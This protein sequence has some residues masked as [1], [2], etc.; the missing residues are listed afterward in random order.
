MYIEMP[1]LITSKEVVH[2][3]NAL[4]YFK[5]D[6]IIS[7]LSE[8]TIKIFAETRY[9]LYI[10]GTLVAV[11]PCKPTSETKYY[12]TVDVSSYLKVGNN[13]LEVF[14][15]QLAY[16]PYGD[17]F[18]LMQSIIRT[19]DMALCV[20]GNCGD[21]DIKSDESWQVAKEK[22]IEF[23]FKQC[24]DLY[25]ETSLSEH[26]FKNNHDKLDFSNCVLGRNIYCFDEASGTCSELELSVKQRP[27]PMMYFTPMSFINQKNGIYDAGK[28]TCGYIRLNCKGK[29]KL[30]VTYAEC[31]VFFEDGKIR[32]RKRDDENG[33]IIGEYDI[34]EVNG[35]CCFEPFWMKTFRFI[36]VEI[37]GNIQ[38][39]SFDYLETG[40]PIE[41]SDKYEFGNE[42]DNKLFEIS[43]NTLKRC[44]HE[45]Y[46]DC[47]Y[48]EQL[49][50]AMDTHLQILFTY[51][52]TTDKALAEKAIDDFASSYRVGG[53]THSRFP[54]IKTQYIPGF[55]LFFILMLY[56][57]SKRFSDT[58]FIKKYIHIADGIIDWFI[59]RLDGFM[60]SRSTLW[61]FID[62]SDEYDFG[63]IPTREPI[64]TY[65]LIFAYTLEKMSEMHK[66]INRSVIDYNILSEEI[67]EDVKRRCYDEKSGL[68]ADTPSKT[69]FSQHQQIWAVLSGVEKGEDAK[70]LLLESTKLKSKI[71]S[72]YMYYY[73]R[74]L[75]NVGLYDLVEEEFNKLRTLV[76]LGCTT[77][78]EWI[79]EDV[80]SECHAWSAIAI[81]EFTA[82]VLGVTYHNN[83]IYIKPYINGRN[84]AK[85]EV[86][87][88]EGMVYCEWEVKNRK[89]TINLKLPKNKRAKLIMP[90]NTE[91][92]AESG[93]YSIETDICQ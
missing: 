6:I 21:V 4:Y 45:T 19:G 62:W 53:L 5:K 13:T 2:N 3:E 37:D 63:Q 82:K 67:K 30:R 68:Y 58:D 12:D 7:N 55:S 48:Y 24:Y 16:T 15:L 34:V 44:M 23:F 50:Y 1:N 33:V 20:W 38:I 84:F 26:I 36:K 75:E 88:P 42:I 41:I 51:Q 65:S 76:D 59:K 83:T 29:G 69:H 77:T 49:Q 35:E 81:Y 40:Y 9:K 71:T 87:T 80:R 86:A 27:I 57:H 90:D 61:D 14:V 79:G 56:E 43:V 25:G 91:I 10:N 47:P 18:T 32:K 73:F 74:A 93:S 60:V 17:A 28:L 66:M 11:G 22:G 54:A 31:R 72:A 78:P 85:G 92:D 64:A 89:F 70:K 52:L 39:D 46:M 8:S